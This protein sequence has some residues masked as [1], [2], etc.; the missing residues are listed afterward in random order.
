MPKLRQPSESFAKLLTYLSYA[1]YREE[2]GAKP[3]S[4]L[5]ALLTESKIF[6]TKFKFRQPLLKRIVDDLSNEVVD[7][8]DIDAFLKQL[9]EKRKLIDHDADVPVEFAKII[10][11]CYSVIRSQNDNAFGRLE[12]N[13]SIFSDPIVNS[14]F[15]PEVADQGDL[16]HKLKKLVKR[17][18]GEERTD[19]SVDER[20]KLKEKKPELLKQYNKLNREF[21]AVP[22]QF[23]TN[24]IRT[25]GKDRVKVRDIVAALNKAKITHS[26]PDGFQGFIDDLGNYY[27]TAELK[28]AAAPAGEILMNPQYDPKKDNTYVCKYKMPMAKDYTMGYTENYKSRTTVDKFKKAGKLVDNMPK[29]RKKWLAEVRRGI[30]N[31]QAMSAMLCE[32]VYQTS[33]RIGSGRGKTDGE[34][35]YGLSTLLVGHVFKKGSKRILKYKGKKGQLQ[36]HELSPSNP[37]MRII[38]EKIDELTDGR[39]RKD[40]LFV[41]SGRKLSAVKVNRYLKSIGIPDGVTIHKFRTARGSQLTK[42]ILEANPFINAKKQPTPKVVNAWFKKSLEQVAK[43]LGHFNNG[44]LTINTAIQNYIDPSI[45]DDFFRQVNVRPSAVIARSIERAKA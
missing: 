27:T 33:G 13:A 2:L 34:T 3:R 11:D 32:L 7:E 31:E 19:I 40:P 12:K 43:E 23:I 37:I 44:K 26:L 29:Y 6:T 8:E 1:M 24:Y 20:K 41:I 38:I 45:L 22:K 42:R 18:V 4:Y 36:T 39:A 17:M 21:R 15:I 9:R 25:S 28:M 5:K 16:E 30:D 35:T 10:K 14:I